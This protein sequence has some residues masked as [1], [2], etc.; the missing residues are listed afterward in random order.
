MVRTHAKR[1]GSLACHAASAAAR[2]AAPRLRKLPRLPRR[3]RRPEPARHPRHS[4]AAVARP[5]SRGCPRRM[6]PGSR[7]RPG[8][9]C[10]QRRA[11]SRPRPLARAPRS[12]SCSNPPASADSRQAI[13]D[14]T[15]CEEPPAQRPGDP[16]GLAGWPSP[17]YRS[18][19]GA[20]RPTRAPPRRPDRSPESARRPTT[21][22]MS[23]CSGRSP[24]RHPN[25]H[26]ATA[27]PPSSPPVTPVIPSTSSS[28]PHRHPE[29]RGISSAR[30]RPR[31]P[32]FLGMTGEPGTALPHKPASSSTHQCTRL[33]VILTITPPAP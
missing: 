29:E 31:D 5:A 24:S 2:S 26:P 8:S 6:L 9:S 13:A 3:A 12:W 28:P 14:A 15:P 25:I 33:S 20:T 27:P 7:G 30:S 19:H 18:R 16:V 23:G 21:P 1:A 22:R 32:S 17:R 11:A 10:P 4:A